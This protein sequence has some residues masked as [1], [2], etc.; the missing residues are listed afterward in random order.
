MSL[1]EGSEELIK[2]LSWPLKPA[3][4]CTISCFGWNKDELGPA[5]SMSQADVSLLPYE[6]PVYRVWRTS[7]C[8][9]CNLVVV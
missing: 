3:I 6:M 8:P 1:I 7:W 5:V 4:R 9:N 2:I